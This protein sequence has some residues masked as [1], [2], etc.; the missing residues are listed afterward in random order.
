[1][2]GAVPLQAP[3][4]ALNLWPCWAVPEIVGG[5]VLTGGA[6]DGV[7]TAVCAELCELDPAELEAVTATRIVVPRSAAT[8]VYVGAL[9]PAM[10][11]QLAPPVSQRRH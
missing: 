4:E 3:V 6:A 2:N 1:V 11:A 5:L 10:S 9:A 7:T 8:S